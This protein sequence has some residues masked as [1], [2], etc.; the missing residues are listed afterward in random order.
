MTS[1]TL[2]NGTFLRLAARLS[3][4]AISLTMTIRDGC[5]VSLEHDGIVYC[6]KDPQQ[7]TTCHRPDDQERN[8]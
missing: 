5:I 6:P 1:V 4:R 2:N 8:L 7:L 3:D